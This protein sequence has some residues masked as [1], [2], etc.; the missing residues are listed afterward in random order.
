M[1]T[2]SRCTAPSRMQISRLSS[3]PVRMGN[4]TLADEQKLCGRRTL[5]LQGGGNSMS[6][7][8]YAFPGTHTLRAR[9]QT[10]DADGNQVVDDRALS[11]MVDLL[12]GADCELIIRIDPLERNLEVFVSNAIAPWEE[13]GQ[14]EVKE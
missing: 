11:G 5:N 14:G 4:S 6:M 7:D 12:M 3:I 2:L 1:R 8:Y 13:G 10:V 9:I